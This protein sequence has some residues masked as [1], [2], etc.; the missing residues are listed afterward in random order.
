MKGSLFDFNN[1]AESY[2]LWYRHP[3]TMKI[4]ELEKK[5]ISPL[6]PSPASHPGVLEV[7]SGTGH[8]TEWLVHSG[9]SVTGI[10]ISKS[11]VQ[12][13]SEKNLDNAMFILGDFMETDFNEQFDMTIAITSLEFIPDYRKAIH[14]MASLTRPGGVIVIGVLNSF[15]YMGI[16]RKIKGD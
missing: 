5:A 16:L 10:D 13:A 6:L 3:V 14:K 15:S 11:M 12:S 2:D 8:W 1:I 4:D 7:G 9:Y